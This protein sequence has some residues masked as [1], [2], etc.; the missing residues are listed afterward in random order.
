MLFA[1]IGYTFAQCSKNNKKYV[2]NNIRK[3]TSCNEILSNILLNF[4]YFHLKL[5][6]SNLTRCLHPL[7]NS[8][9]LFNN[10]LSLTCSIRCTISVKPSEQK[11]IFVLR[12]TFSTID[13][14]ILD[15][16]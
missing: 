13:H 15:I 4:S 5:L 7:M 14:L 12:Y 3:N 6:S 2:E 11:L 1:I 8:F 9:F 10:G 16:I